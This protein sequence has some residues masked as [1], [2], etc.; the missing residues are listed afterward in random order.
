MTFNSITQYDKMFAEIAKGKFGGIN[1]CPFFALITALKFLNKDN[2]NSDIHNENVIKAVLNHV[3]N[4]KGQ[5]MTF[6]D[7]IGNFTNIDKK[8]I[9]ATSVVLIKDNIIGYDHIFEKKNKP[10]CV[11]FLKN[12]KFFVVTVSSDLK[13]SVHDCHEKIQVINLNFDE[14]KQYLN[15]TYQ[16]DKEINLDGY[17]I[18][19]FSNIEYLPIFEPFE[20]KMNLNI[21]HEL[22]VKY[23]SMPKLENK[24]EIKEI[25]EKTE[26][27]ED[28][29]VYKIKF[30]S[31]MFPSNTVDKQFAKVR[32]LNNMNSY[33]D[34][35]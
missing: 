2:N 16:F 9:N 5:T 22:L 27:I 20:T 6:N 8:N 24:Q 34:F 7:L 1:F 18:E 29:I 21:E 32:S 15:Q 30:D 35:D 12:G 26:E 33:V 31:S 3:T 14:I 25:K 28:D 17:K 23:R 13:F 4:N 11:I 10:Y 19:E